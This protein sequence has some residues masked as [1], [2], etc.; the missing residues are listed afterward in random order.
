[1]N[2]KRDDV[3]ELVNEET[4][5]KPHRPKSKAFIN[6]IKYKRSIF[7]LDHFPTLNSSLQT[8]QSKNNERKK[9]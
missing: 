6:L 2:K 5:K 1:M 7:F 3:G 8:T 9:L 4:H